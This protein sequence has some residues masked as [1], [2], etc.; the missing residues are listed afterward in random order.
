MQINE[1]MANLTEQLVTRNAPLDKI[2]FLALMPYVLVYQSHILW[3]CQSTKQSDMW[4]IFGLRAS[5]LH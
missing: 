1:L 4:L 3:Q 2:K 5:V